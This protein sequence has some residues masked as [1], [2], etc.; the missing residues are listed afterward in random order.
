[1]PGTPFRALPFNMSEDQMDT[2]GR[3][4]KRRSR[5]RG[6]CGSGDGSGD[7]GGGGSGVGVGGGVGGGGGTRYNGKMGR[8]MHGGSR[9]MIVLNGSS[10]E[11]LGVSDILYMLTAAECANGGRVPQTGQNVSFNLKPRVTDAEGFK[12]DEHKPTNVMIER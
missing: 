12:A 5:T 9:G 8:V 3:G 2:E 10:M 4:I 1:M 7:G 11:K 6:D